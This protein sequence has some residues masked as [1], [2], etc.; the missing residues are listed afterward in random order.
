MLARSFLVP[1]ALIFGSGASEK[2]GEEIGKLGVKKGLIV[3][4]EVLLKLGILEGIEQ[5]LTQARI[6]F[7]IYSGVFTEPTVEFV[8]EGLKAYKENGCDFLLAVGFFLISA[9]PSRRAH[10]SSAGLGFGGASG[11]H[12]GILVP[13][14]DLLLRRP[15][16]PRASRVPRMMW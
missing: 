6:Q 7:E 12:L 4:D 13:Y 10:P 3:T 11:P 16:T 14:L 9:I 1:P 5:A 2:V 8:E 15:S